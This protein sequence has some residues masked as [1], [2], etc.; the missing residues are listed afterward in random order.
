MSAMIAGAVPILPAFTATRGTWK[1]AE[2]DPIAVSVPPDPSEN[3]GPA[4]PAPPLFDRRAS[5]SERGAP[6]SPDL[7]YAIMRIEG[8]YNPGRLD[9]TGGVTRMSVAAGTASMSNVF[10]DRWHFGDTDANVNYSVRYLAQ[11]WQKSDAE[12]CSAYSKHRPT[13]G[14]VEV[15]SLGAA[16]CA[17]I[18]ALRGPQEAVW[19]QLTIAGAPVSVPVFAAPEPGARLSPEAFWAAQKARIEAIK[20]RI[21]FQRSRARATSVEAER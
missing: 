19:R 17:R 1:A 11:A 7:D 2:P 16:D 4:M 8:I 12:P 14:I 6:L 9:A 3:G 13:L 21:E 15:T 20:A 10:A 5:A 18:A